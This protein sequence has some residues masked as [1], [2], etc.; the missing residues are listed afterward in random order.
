MTGLLRW[1]TVFHLHLEEAVRFEKREISVEFCAVLPF[2]LHTFYHLVRVWLKCTL[3][4][5]RVLLP[6]NF[7]MMVG[8]ENSAVVEKLFVRN[9][10]KLFD[11]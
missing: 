8:I 5:T 3:L 4:G 7:L 10:W 11:G 9:L 6:K 2:F 1:T